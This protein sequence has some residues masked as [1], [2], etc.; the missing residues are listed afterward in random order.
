MNASIQAES[1]RRVS[2]CVTE[3]LR[4]QP[5]F[6]SLALRLPLEPDPTRQTLAADGRTIRYS[7]RGWCRNCRRGGRAFV[8]YGRGHGQPRGWQRRE[9]ER[10][11]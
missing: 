6:G 2:A 9:R 11:R 7:P 5:F 1:A 10:R 4:K 8:G 3:L